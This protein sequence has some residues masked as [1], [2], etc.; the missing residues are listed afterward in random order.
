ML[1][2]LCLLLALVCVYVAITV[3][4]PGKLTEKRDSSWL[5]CFWRLQSSRAWCWTWLLVMATLLPLM[6]GNTKTKKHLWKGETE[7]ETQHWE[8]PLLEELMETHGRD[9]SLPDERLQS[10]YGLGHFVKAQTS[11]RLH[12]E[13]NFTWSIAGSSCIQTISVSKTPCTLM[14]LL[15]F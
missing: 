6:M 8:R 9:D 12:W 11:T 2:L 10:S 13:P 14:L 7:G 1:C 3:C 5:S 4:D 15:C